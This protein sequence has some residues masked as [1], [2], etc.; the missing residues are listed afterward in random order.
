MY[1][2]IFSNSTSSHVKQARHGCYFL[3]FQRNLELQ[4][5]SSSN[6]TCICNLLS[7]KEKASSL[8][9]R[10]I[11]FLSWTFILYS[12]MSTKQNK[13]C[14]NKHCMYIMSIHWRFSTYV[15]V[16]FECVFEI[17]RTWQPFNE[18]LCNPEN[19]PV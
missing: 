11:A 17:M 2:S 13:V 5:S 18:C 4:V 6:L 9:G 15:T 14:V 7:I 16:I 3:F 19:S 8:G 12:T 10:L 1:E